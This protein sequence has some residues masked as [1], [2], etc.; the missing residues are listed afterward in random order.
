ML[1]DVVV[2]ATTSQRP[3]PQSHDLL[4]IFRGLWL[5]R[6]RAHLKS[7]VWLYPW[8]SAANT[9]PSLGLLDPNTIPWPLPQTPSSL[10]ACLSSAS[11]FPKFV[12]SHPSTPF[13]PVAKAPFSLLP[14]DH[15]HRDLGC[16]GD[17]HLWPVAYLPAP[18]TT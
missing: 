11:C 1:S 2:V 5:S 10:L 13:Y 4:C 16:F 12:Q 6:N 15:T 9:I 17:F 7:S 18:F 8:D 3:L 14:K